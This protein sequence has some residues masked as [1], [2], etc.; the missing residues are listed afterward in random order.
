M[1][2]L[3]MMLSALSWQ[4]ESRSPDL[5]ENV[6]EAREEVVRYSRSEVEKRTGVGVDE[7]F[8]DGQAVVRGKSEEEK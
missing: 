2:V 6:R 4:C 5:G 3:H 1:N 8:Q 7:L